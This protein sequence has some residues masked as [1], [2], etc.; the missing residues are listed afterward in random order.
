MRKWIVYLMVFVFASVT[1]ASG[2]VGTDV[3]K[4]LPVEVVRLSMEM[5]Q[6]VLETDTGDRGVGKDLEEALRTLHES[7]EGTIFLETAD[8]LILQSGS[9][10]LLEELYR[11]L[12]PS[13]GLYLEE[14]KTDPQKIT[15]FLAIHRSDVTLRDWIG[16]IKKMPVLT[17]SEGRI[18]LVS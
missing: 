3:G 15:K 7:A 8:N 9:E 17:E 13:C 16:G 14:K 10:Y 11:I 4:L 5:G 12:R 2:F 18:I 6:V 1:D